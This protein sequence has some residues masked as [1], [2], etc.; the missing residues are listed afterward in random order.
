MQFDYEDVYLNYQRS[1][2]V[3][4]DDK[5]CVGRLLP[6]SL[7][8]DVLDISASEVTSKKRIIGNSQTRKSVGD[9]PVSFTH[10]LKKTVERTARPV[11]LALAL[12]LASGIWRMLCQS[13]EMTFLKKTHFRIVG[14]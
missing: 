8:G 3:D 6:V 5:N 7:H 11:R 14:I 9:V 4:C 13:P 10:G 12:L 1:R 2:G